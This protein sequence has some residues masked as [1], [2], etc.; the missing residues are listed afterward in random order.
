MASWCTG[1]FQMHGA[2]GLVMLSFSS[3]YDCG[4]SAFSICYSSL[5]RPHLTMACKRKVLERICG[6]WKLRIM[7]MP[8]CFFFREYRRRSAS[9]LIF[10]YDPE[11]YQG[12]C[13]SLARIIS[14]AHQRP[15]SQEYRVV[16]CGDAEVSQEGRCSAEWCDRPHASTNGPIGRP[17][18]S[19]T[20]SLQEYTKM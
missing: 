2:H 18:L 7:K 5:R 16:L 20:N 11:G 1:A 19:S 3:D 14:E 8:Q 13:T 17:S 6:C 10:I 4:D 9:W 15:S 12:S